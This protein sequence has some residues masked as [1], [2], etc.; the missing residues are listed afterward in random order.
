MATCGRT[1]DFG[2]HGSGVPKRYWLQGRHAA[3]AQE[4]RQG[5]LDQQRPFAGPHRAG[6]RNFRAKKKPAPLALTL[7]GASFNYPASPWVRLVFDR[8]V[9]IA[10]P[11]LLPGITVDDNVSTDNFFA[12]TGTA[13][14]VD[15]VTVQVPLVVTGS[16]HGGSLRLLSAPGNTGVVAADDGGT[17]AG[18]GD[19]SIPF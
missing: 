9:N 11:L 8:P 6:H 7:V 2:R 13:T 18:A 10:G 16:A 12:G 1:L 14:L 4:H 19:L 3:H 5:R 17:W 15:S